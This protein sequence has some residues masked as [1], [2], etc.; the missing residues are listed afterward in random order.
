MKKKKI[1]KILLLLLLCIIVGIISYFGTLLIDKAKRGNDVDVNV[2]FDDTLT[3]VIP[4]TKKMTKE[5]ALEEW[6][7]MMSV[8]NSGKDKGLYQIIINDIETSTISRDKLDYSL[9]LDDKEIS[10][11][12]LKDIKND[13][14]YTYEIEGK[15]TQRYKVYIWV[16]SEVEEE[17]LYEYKLTFNTIKTGGP[18]F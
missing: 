1:I 6:P 7:Y 18:G 13:I 10:S 15:K 5:E 12:K 8:S 2:I 14:L 3:Y 9:Y 17:S 4:S 11:G 16:N